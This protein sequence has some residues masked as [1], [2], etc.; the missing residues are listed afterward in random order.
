MW[1]VRS[2]VV[3]ID[4]SEP[5]H[6]AFEHAVAI[7][8]QTGASV[9]VVHVYEFPLYGYYGAPIAMPIPDYSDTLRKAAEARLEAFLADHKRPEGRL[10]GSVRP[11][12]PWEQ[13][14]DTASEKKADLIVMA[15]HGRRGLPR[16][17]LG[18]VAEK[19]VRMSTIPVLSV[20]IGEQAA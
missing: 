16:A 8:E 13:I 12:V 20:R 10:T 4:F 9:H 14:L 2:I 19:V 11:G 15:T 17:L 1:S 6:A 18:S 3:P 7:A 5:S